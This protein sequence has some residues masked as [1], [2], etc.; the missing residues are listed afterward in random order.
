MPRPTVAPIVY[1]AV[2]RGQTLLAEC[3]TGGVSPDFSTV[4]ESLLRG[5]PTSDAT[6]YYLHEGHTIQMLIRHELCYV[7]MTKDT[8][9]RSV[10]LG[11]LKEVMR[12]FQLQ[13]GERA[14]FARS[15]ACD[16]DFKRTLRQLMEETQATRSG[17]QKLVAIQS[18]IDS[19]KRIME[20]NIDKA[21]GRGEKL[22]VLVDKSDSLVEKSYVFHS[23]SRAVQRRFFCQNMRVTLLLL[24]VVLIILFIGVTTGCGGF[25][26][27]KCK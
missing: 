19:A 27:S 3:S 2:A 23:Q 24:F 14:Q 6:L 4:L 18:E 9:S 20:E 13:F 1:A 5:A 17:D 11:F 8:M 15:L 25:S 16:A 22:E 12:A 10:T 21:I 26:Y 7:A